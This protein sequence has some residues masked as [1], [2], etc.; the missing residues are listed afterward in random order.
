MYDRVTAA[1]NREHAGKPLSFYFIIYT[2]DKPL[3]LCRCA[4]V[5]GGA[6]LIPTGV[7]GGG[8]P[9]RE[10]T[11]PHGNAT[12]HSEMDCINTEMRNACER[13]DLCRSPDPLPTVTP[14]ANP[15]LTCR[16]P[17]A[18]SALP[19]ATASLHICTQRRMAPLKY[20]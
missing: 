17:K 14:P 6:V 12:T 11:G 13:R 8:L 9:Q 20:F 3:P 15:R 1:Q 10:G 2:A 4:A 16:S 18:S 19:K 5:L 7:L